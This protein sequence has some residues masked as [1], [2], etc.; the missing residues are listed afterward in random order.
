MNHSTRNTLLRSLILL[1]LLG[2][3]VSLL[4][5][6][7]AQ[8]T[9]KDSAKVPNAHSCGSQPCP[10]STGPTS[11]IVYYG[12]SL[13][14]GA[15]LSGAGGGPTVYVIW[16]G[17]WNQN[18]GTDTPQGQQLV[19][20]FLY[21]LSI[22][23]DSPYGSPYFN[24]NSTLSAVSSGGVLLA[25]NGKVAFGGSCSLGYLFG[26]TLDRAFPNIV[27]YALCGTNPPLLPNDSNG[28]YLVLTSSD[29]TGKTAA[30]GFCQVC[31]FHASFA[32]PICGTDIKIAWAGNAAMCLS[33]CAAQTVSP[34]GNAGVDGMLDTVAHELAEATT[35]PDFTAWYTSTDTDASVTQIF[36]ETGD[37]C[38]WTYGQNLPQLDFPK[39]GRPYYNV[40]LPSLNTG[41]GAPLGYRN[42]L[43]QRLLAHNV[44]VNGVTG[45]FCAVSYDPVTGAITQ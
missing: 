40:T 23:P 39:Y 18:N 24:I 34:N 32:N 26:S 19:Y 33:K 20:D 45:D 42:Y 25:V 11:P 1:G 5:S 3:A 21:G 15:D 16:Y 4:V 43:I 27:S 36:G 44:T 29:V 2:A 28:I 35:D 13:L 8:V 30:G 14:T 31:G 12:G 17:N 10:G 6:A 37:K 38:V 7:S 9:Q 41:P 22:G